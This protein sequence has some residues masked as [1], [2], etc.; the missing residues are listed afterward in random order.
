[1]CTVL[2]YI[3]PEIST[4]V[5]SEVIFF[6][7]IRYGKFQLANHLM[8]QLKVSGSNLTSVCK[9]VFKVTRHDAN[10]SLF[11]EGNLLDLLLEAVACVPPL[12]QPEACVYGY[13]ALKFLTMNSQLVSR[14]LNRGVLELLVLHMKLIVN[15]VSFSHF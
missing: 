2:T 12:E 4:S 9:L 8:L 13:G 10:D 15:H 14:L 5:V 6:H 7:A 11:L 1:M 3:K